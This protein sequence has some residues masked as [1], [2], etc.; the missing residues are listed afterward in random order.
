MNVQT[1]QTLMILKNKVK[2][3]EIKNTR[4][5]KISKFLLQI[6]TYAY[7]KVMDLLRGRFDHKTLTTNGFS[8]KIHLHHSHVTRKFMDT[9]MI[10][11]T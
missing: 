11:V 9:L 10:F 4:N 8:E 2:D 5:S 1:I 7:H 3:V 6:Y